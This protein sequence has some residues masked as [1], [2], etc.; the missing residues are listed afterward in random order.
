[1]STLT[2]EEKLKLE[3]EDLWN[4]CESLLNT[5]YEL[6][7]SSKVE[8]ISNTVLQISTFMI[9]NS[10]S[11]EMEMVLCSFCKEKDIFN[12]IYRWTGLNRKYLKQMAFVQLTSFN[13][14]VQKAGRKLL[15]CKQVMIPLLLL[16]LSLKPTD[17][18]RIPPEVEFLYVNILYNIS[19]RIS[20]T[21]LL[22]LLS[23]DLYTPN[24]DFKISRFTFFELLLFYTH[25][26]GEVGEMARLAIL[27][28]LK[29]AI[30]ND[31]LNEFICHQT[32]ACAVS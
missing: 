12:K 11:D 15:G 30:T 4:K 7:D 6:L 9:E 14:L 13:A 22:D 32:A 23:H 8:T 25:K 18:R 31:P 10:T 1:M 20:N 28:C 27:S 19:Q 16:M 2:N 26:P 21:Y 24:E 17:T 3:V 5:E 29:F